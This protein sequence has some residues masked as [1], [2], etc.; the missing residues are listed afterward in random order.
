M[1]RTKWKLVL[2][3]MGVALPL[4]TG[5]VMLGRPAPVAVQL[6]SPAEGSTIAPGTLVIQWTGGDPSMSVDIS[7]FDITPGIPSVG[8]GVAYGI[9][10]TGAFAWTFPSALALNG[11]CGHSY[12]FYLQES[13]QASWTN[14]PVFT[15]DCGGSNPPLVQP[16]VL[17]APGGGSTQM[18]GSTVT[19][20]WA[21]GDPAWSVNLSLIDV[22]ANQSIFSVASSIPNSGSFDWQIPREFTGC[23]RTYKF[24]VENVQRLDWGYGP[25]F[26]IDCKIAQPP[27]PK[28]PP[29]PKAP[30]PPLFAFD[31]PLPESEAKVCLPPYMI[32]QP[33]ETHYWWARATGDRSLSVTLVGVGV[34]D[35]EHGDAIV[36]VYNPDNTLA[37]STAVIQPGQGQET[38]AT[39]VQAFSTA[40]GD[41]YRIEVRI[42]AVDKSPVARHYRL[43]LQGASVLGTNSVMPSQAEHHAA[44]WGVNVGAAGIPER[45]DVAVTPGPEAGATPGVGQFTLV[46]PDGTQF[47]ANVGGVVT[48][49]D[50]T[51]AGMWDLVVP[52]LDGHYVALKKSPTAGHDAGIYANW[53]TWGSGTI[54]GYVTQGGTGIGVPVEILTV[55]GNVMTVVQAGKDGFYEIKD[56]PPG[57]YI[58]RPVVK[59]K[60]VKPGRVS[61][62]CTDQ[63]SADFSIPK[64]NEPP[65]AGD[66]SASG[67]ED[68]SISGTTRTNDSDP[69]GD[70]LTSTLVS[71]VTNGT[72]V[73]ND[74]GTFV[75]TPP[76]N[77]NGTDSF[78]YKVSDGSL[79]G[80]V[81]TVTLTVMPVNDEPV[82]SG[83]PTINE[84]WPPNHKYVSVGI[85]GLT[86]IDGDAVS[87]AVSGIFQDE[88]TNTE[89]DG[90]TPVD[91]AGLGSTA[92]QVRAERA[93]TPKVP[94]N[95]RVYHIFY[96]GSDS[97]GGSCSG[98]VKVGVPH[99]QGNKRTLVDD[100][101]KYNSVTGAKVP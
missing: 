50:A 13:N 36:E 75:Y 19:I 12:R 7:L 18:A 73:F 70:N 68:T 58:V 96:T 83:L 84:I 65:A 54:S 81:A 29:K 53:M 41:L 59:G 63:A 95:G 16:F 25:E 42:R 94:G 35:A 87:V 20:A 26:V 90:N 78:T 37:G 6:T 22:A 10:N 99:D 27:P 45:V 11:P 74:D 61:L 9:T 80:N 21:G 86:D 24:H 23:G 97:N 67:N 34:N 101:I 48:A 77:Y 30:L 32:Q 1:N 56:L 100:G 93:G 92:A 76:A 33:S 15:V 98:E 40:A 55:D 79:S 64:T 8:I 38:E 2:A 39:A 4:W 60:G 46:S 49:P 66:D 62:Y 88:P 14:G 89:G 17:T 91:A 44:R 57:T 72:L 5:S 82:C 3:V 71:G 52:E 28:E 31:R 43:M 47:S 51:L 69:D 85:F